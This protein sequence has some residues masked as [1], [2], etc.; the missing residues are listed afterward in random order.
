[1]QVD[2]LHLTVNYTTYGDTTA[3]EC[4]SFTWHGITYKSTPATAPTYTI[5]GGNHVGCDSVVTLHLTILPAYVTILEE[6]VHSGTHFPFMWNGI[7]ITGPGNYTYKT[8]ASNGCD[9][10]V[11]INFVI[12]GCDIVVTPTVTNEI[13]GNDGTIT[14][15]ATGGYSDFYY[16]VDAGVNFYTSPVFTGLS[17]GFYVVVVHDDF[18]CYTVGY[19]V[20]HPSHGLSISCAPNVYD[21]LAFGECMME[22]PIGDI[23]EPA[24]NMTNINLDVSHYPPTTVSGTWTYPRLA[25]WP[26]YTV[27][28]D[29]PTDNMYAEGD[30]VITWT[31]ND[32]VCGP[33]TCQQH[34]YVTFPECP[35]AVDCEG[36]VYHGV[37]IDC[38]CWTQT[39]LKSTR[40][41]D[42]S[43]IPT[44]YEYYSSMTPN[45][46]ENVERFG[47]LYSFESAV[48]DSA[49]N[50]HGHIQGICPVG[51]YLPTPEKY[52]TLALHGAD[53]LKS[54]LYWLDGGGSNM[55]G[56][57]A[58]PAGWYN[59]DKD[60]YEGM[61]GETYF[62]ST[63]GVKATTQNSAFGLIFKCDELF[64]T[65]RKL[66]VGYSVRCIKERK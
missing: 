7:N 16:S 40:Y 5:V 15:S 20:V 48:R 47:R 4:G 21:T 9:S 49:D 61:Y 3:V 27:T 12:Q 52:E 65:D 34:V 37:R 59:G 55:T 19:G 46:A 53:A 1:M 13:C 31:V 17:A 43:L 44:V 18:G 33:K 64:E 25:D 51:W 60:R 10:T 35:D 66:G 58:L 42:C 2:T 29:K 38:D 6:T 8:T 11:K 50:G 26:T 54:P 23:S 45:V 39:N 63:E 28:S 24:V 14:V 62:W 32:P 56:F 36:N 30:N 22:I 41:S 57:S